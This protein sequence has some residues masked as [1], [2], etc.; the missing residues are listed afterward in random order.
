MLRNLQTLAKTSVDNT[1]DFI[2][3]QNSS[4]GVLKKLLAAGLFPTMSTTGTGGQ[5]IFVS[6]TNKN[7]LNFKGIKS[8][9]TTKFTATT[10]TNNVLLTLVESGIDLSNCNNAT[11]G[12]L[13]AMDFSKLL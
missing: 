2:E 1:Y 11:S 8:A 12:F 6:V 3:I 7:Q 13:T 5:D 10:D 9:D 4:T